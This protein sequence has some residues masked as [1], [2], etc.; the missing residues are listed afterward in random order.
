MKIVIEGELTDFNTFQDKTRWNK[1][2]GSNLK[3]SETER[4]F[5]CCKKQPQEP[6]KFYP[7]YISFNWYSPNN[8]KDTDNVAFAKKFILDGLVMAGLLKGDGRKYVAGFSDNFYIDK[9]NPRCE[10]TI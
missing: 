5:W 4:V 8:K 1:Y 9:E 2:S 7:V 6:V 10:V 3:K